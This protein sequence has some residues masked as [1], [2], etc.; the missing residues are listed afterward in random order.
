MMQIAAYCGL[1]DTLTVDNFLMPL[2]HKY[3]LLGEGEVRKEEL[4]KLQRIDVDQS[5]AR[6]TSMFEV[7]AFEVVQGEALRS[8]KL[9]PP[10]HARLQD[11]VN[12]AGNG[13]KRLFA[14]RCTF[15]C[16]GWN[17][18]RTRSPHIP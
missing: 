6:A 17:S 13:I 2:V 14:Y 10:I 15:V 5:G 9:T 16:S 18:D 1:H 4:A 12:G 11:E 8:L 3:G 7:F